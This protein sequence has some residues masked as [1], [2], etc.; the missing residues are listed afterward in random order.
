MQKSMNAQKKDRKINID[1][2][3][4]KL[5]PFYFVLPRISLDREHLTA[6]SGARLIQSTGIKF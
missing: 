5:C 1:S 6:C 3:I 2:E 4:I